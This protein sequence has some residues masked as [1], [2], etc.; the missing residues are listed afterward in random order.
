MNKQAVPRKISME[1]ALSGSHLLP[2][3]STTVPRKNS[4]ELRMED[5]TAARKNSM[6][7]TACEGTYG[8]VHYVSNLAYKI[9]MDL[10]T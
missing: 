6:A 3:A 5:K 2:E 1:Q 10:Q 8:C 9:L 4:M 7:A